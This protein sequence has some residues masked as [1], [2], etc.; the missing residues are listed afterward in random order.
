MS[1]MNSVLSEFSWNRLAD[2]Q[3]VT[4]LDTPQHSAAGGR[5]LM[6]HTHRRRKG[7]ATGSAAG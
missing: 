3:S 6:G 1:H 2:I 4:D 7:A 5:R